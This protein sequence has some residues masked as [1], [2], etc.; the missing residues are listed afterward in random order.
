MLSPLD[1]LL[2]HQIPETFDRVGTSDRNFFD[3]YYFNVHACS[4]ELFMIVGMGQYPN[5]GVTDAFVVLVQDGV[6]RLVRASRELGANR[7]D[8]QVGPIGVQVLEGL[9]SLRVTCDPNEW[10]VDFDLVWEAGVPANEEPPSFQRH[11]ARVVSDGR[12]FVQT[13]RWRGYLRVGDA[14]HEVTPD[15]WWGGRDHSWGIRPVGEPEPPGIRTRPEG[16]MAC[17]TPMQFPDWS[18]VSFAFEDAHGFRTGESAV[19]LHALGSGRATEHLG[20]PDY[21]LT[22]EPGSRRL[23]EATITVPVPDADPLVV[24]ATPLTRICLD[25]GTGYGGDADWRHGMYQGPLKV[26]GRSW[27][28]GELFPTSGIDASLCRY[29]CG[30]AVGYGVFDLVVAGVHRPSGFTSPTDVGPPLPA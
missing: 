23:H 20:R 18:L 25:K 27:P 22:F 21:A 5:L 24:R 17:W 8:T 15:R 7:L 19:R 30:D 16:V 29:E 4:G 10:D 9:V 14:V 3:R 26:E 6:Q 2:A 13:G 12:R 1:D 11:L 28:Q